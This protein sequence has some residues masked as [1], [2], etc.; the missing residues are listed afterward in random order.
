MFLIKL[1]VSEKKMIAFFLFRE[2]LELAGVLK[3]VDAGNKA[4]GEET[5]KQTWAWLRR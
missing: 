2:A 3:D 4:W 1:I 5:V